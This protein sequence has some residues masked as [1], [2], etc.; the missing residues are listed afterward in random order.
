MIRSAEG[1][2]R[3]R[4]AP[5][6]ASAPDRRER[7]HAARRAAARHFRSDFP[8]ED[9]AFRRHVVLRR[10]HEPVLEPWS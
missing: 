9:D 7:A 6:A 4:K 5:G 2:E 3:L 10:G 8:T 1:L